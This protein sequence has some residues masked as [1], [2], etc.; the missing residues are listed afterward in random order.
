MKIS[1]LQIPILILAIAVGAI[2][3]CSKDAKA[4]RFMDRGNQ[5]FQK[6]EFQAAEIEYLNVLKVGGLKPAA[7]RQLGLIYSE[8]GRLLEAFSYLQKAAE[9]EPENVDVRLKLGLA[10]L[11]LRKFK[12]AGEQATIVLG[13]QPGNEEAIL[14]LAESAATPE[15][16]QKVLKKIEA[17]RQGDRDRPSYHLALGTLY[18]RQ[19]KQSEAESEVNIAL[20]MDSKSAAANIA[21]GNLLWMKNDLKGAEPLLKKGSELAPLR[22]SR[23]L[24]YA[25]FKIKTGDAAAAKKILE[26]ITKQAEDFVP[27]WSYLMEVA[28]VERRFE[29]CATL[30]KKVLALDPINY[31]ALLRSG[32][33]NLI[34]NEPDKAITVFQRMTPIYDTVP[35]VHY[36]MALA[37]L[38]KKD[39]TK[40]MSSL[41]Q[42]LTLNP[43]YAEASQLAAELNIKRG[44][45]AVAIPSLQNNLKQNPKDAKSHLLLAAAYSSQ[46]N[47][48]EAAAVY[49]RMMPLFPTNR[50]V[51]LLLGGVFL[52]DNKLAEARGAFQKCLDISP[53]YF[54]AVEQLV[55]LDLAGKKY[56]SAL[57]RVKKEVE[58]QP[59]AGQ[60]LLLLAMVHLS[61]RK[62]DEGEAAILKALELEPNLPSAYNMLVQLYIASNRH[63]DALEKLEANAIKN[64]K[65]QATLMQ[66]GMLHEGMTNYTAARDA[67][68]KLIDVNP[69][70]YAPLNNLAY[71]YSERFGQLDK[72]ADLAKR[73]RKLSEDPSTA[74]TLGWILYKKQDYAAALPLLQ[75][76]ASSTALSSNPE[77]IFHLGMAQSM[78]GEESRARA[79]L[80]RAIESSVAFPGKEAGRSR[81]ALL[82]IDSKTA[83]A[84]VLKDLEKRQRDEPGDPVVLA[85]LA[86]IYE[87][88]GNMEKAVKS[89]EGVLKKNPQHV[90]AMMALARYYSNQPN[91]PSKPLDLVNEARRLAPDDAAITYELARLVYNAGDYKRASSL[92][93]ESA[94]KLSNDPNVRYDLALSH[95]SVGLVAEAEESAKEALKLNGSF[96]RAN[97]AK[98]FLA[99]IDVYK[100]PNKAA[101][102]SADVQQILKADANYVPAAM[103]SA[104][105]QKQKGELK[106]AI[107]VY[108]GILAK[109]PLFLPASRE[110]VIL[111]AEVSGDDQK[112]Y[113]LG[114][115]TRDSYPGDP[116]LAKALGI[117][118]YRR[119]DYKRS[120]QLLKESARTRQD[121]ASIYYYVGLGHSKLKENAESKAAFQRALALNLDEKLS[122]DAKRVMAEMK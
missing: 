54:P 41:N 105:L 63:K 77:V 64:P 106:G 103:V 23:R 31:D 37:Y 99:M 71:L 104:V 19:K 40:A 98:R 18:L 67:Y 2:T 3:G 108:E 84:E 88:D 7:V 30:N 9:L 38:M 82:A 28:F 46:K 6:G 13:K 25:D 11:S 85:R 113:A 42:A 109:N 121:D 116:E 33:L 119:Q 65:D 52:Q 72:A 115:K 111:Y 73:A 10:Y 78:M 83:S 4:K 32:M 8:Q 47:F 50:E 107:G 24:A 92:F 93:Q 53:G 66:I 68:E 45:P 79:S 59:K 29:D 120:I 44:N 96:P 22:S 36:Q 70:L 56:D 102:A 39:S 117:L 90:P 34:E 76:S 14:L 80:Q 61:Q 75:E 100:H 12:E 101:A 110:V 51:P 74:D 5:S 57:A 43:D 35:Q 21:A 20:S 122:A 49:Q 60:P 69:D 62:T 86:A 17:L 81:L 87:R 15:E 95:Y 97:D 114:V 16:S 1:R 55:Y 91:P 118:A 58:K 48:N 26:E 89:Y 112:A 27:A 94:R